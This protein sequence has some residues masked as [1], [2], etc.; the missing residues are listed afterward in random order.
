MKE[1][2]FFYVVFMLQN[3]LFLFQNQLFQLVLVVQSVLLIQL[4]FL[5]LPHQGFLTI[6]SLCD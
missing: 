4:L 1:V 3:L 2:R 6:D 5:G